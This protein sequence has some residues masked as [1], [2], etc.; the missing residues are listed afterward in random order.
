MLFR[1][2]NH[3]VEKKIVPHILTRR[4]GTGMAMGFIAKDVNIALDTARAIGGFMPLAE[5]VSEL[6]TAAAEK[7]GANRDQA[8]VA[9]YWE[10]ANGVTLEA[11]SRKL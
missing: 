1:S 10:E 4:F 5:R 8:E 11:T 2:R 9:R 7:V 3:P 6:W